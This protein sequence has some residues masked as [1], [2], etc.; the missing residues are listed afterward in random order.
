MAGPAET[1]II[2]PRAVKATFASTVAGTVKDQFDKECRE[3]GIPQSAA[4]HAVGQAA[5]WHR[6]WVIQEE[7]GHTMPH[8]ADQWIFAIDAMRREA[9]NPSLSDGSASPQMCVPQG[10]AIIRPIALRPQEGIPLP[11]V[12]TPP[13]VLSSGLESP[14]SPLTLP[15]DDYSPVALD[16]LPFECIAGPIPFVVLQKP[17]PALEL[18][19]DDLLHALAVSGGDVETKAFSDALLPLVRHYAESGWDACDP[20]GACSK[21]GGTKSIEGLW[22][23]LTKASYFG[24]L[25]EN[26]D[27]DPM[28]TLGRMSF[29]MFL[30]TQLVCSLQGNFNPVKVVTPEE[31]LELMER[32]PKSLREEIGSGGAILRKYE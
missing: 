14:S 26:P 19:K 10:M 1:I 21:N 25:G 3:A 22:L 7:E 11:L 29:D 23:T 30:P 16:D 2:R 27:G 6:R 9:M 28:Y 15:S 8:D 4:E 5:E 17:T 24:C 20:E 31:R 18:A 12:A 32:C 13:A